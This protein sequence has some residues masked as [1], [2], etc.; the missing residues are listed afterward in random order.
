M[1]KPFLA[2]FL[3][4]YA[5]RIPNIVKWYSFDIHQLF[6]QD[7]QG[8]EETTIIHSLSFIGTTLEATNMS[9]FKRVSKMK[10][11]MVVYLC[12]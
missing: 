8:G 4:G 10:Y 12:I 11:C 7:N 1:E 6:I 9:D 5:L 3:A 2:L